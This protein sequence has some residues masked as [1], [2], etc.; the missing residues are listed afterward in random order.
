MKAKE[1]MLGDWV[2]HPK[3]Q[4][5]I[6][7]IQ[8]NDVVFTDYADNIDGACDIDDLEPIEITEDWLE[9]NFERG[10]NYIG[11][12]DDYFD[13]YIRP[14]QDGIWMLTYSS[15]EMSLPIESVTVSWVHELQHFLTH[16]C[17]DKELK[18]D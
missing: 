11:I 9:K 14:I 12:Y 1:L 13:F 7:A 5:R 17:I 6:T 15:C 10:G 16:C 18:M 4:N 2:K 3:G 8:D